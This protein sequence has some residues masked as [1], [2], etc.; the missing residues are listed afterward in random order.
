MKDPLVS[1]ALVGPF[2]LEGSLDHSYLKLGDLVHEL[3]KKGP[4]RYA[5]AGGIGERFAIVMYEDLSWR[6]STTQYE[7]FEEV[8]RFKPLN[9]PHVT[10]PEGFLGGFS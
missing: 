8:V 10:N 6:V 1:E 9:T 7:L 2:A 3:K 4:G 5:I